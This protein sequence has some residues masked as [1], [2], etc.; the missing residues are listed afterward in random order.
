MVLSEIVIYFQ[1]KLQICFTIATC[2]HFGAICNIGA[3]AVE[4]GMEMRIPAS[5]GI[6]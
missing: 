6:R 2:Y 1:I 5:D 4:I 3:C